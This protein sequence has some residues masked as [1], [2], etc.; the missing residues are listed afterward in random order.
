[1]KTQ[2]LKTLALSLLLATSVAGCSWFGGS[3]K[4]AAPPAPLVDFKASMNPA[5]QWRADV[6]SAG[7][8]MFSP[9]VTAD[10]VYAAGQKGTLARFDLASGKQLWRIDTGS[11]LSAGVGVGDDVVSVVTTTGMVLAY[12]ASGKKMWQAQSPGEVLAAPIVSGGKVIVR[13]DDGRIVAFSSSDGKQDWFY[14]RNNP[15]LTLRSNA[16]AVVAQ[17]AVFAGFPGGKLVGINLGNGAVGW[18]ATVST[19]RGATELERVTDVTSNPVLIGAMICA[20]SYQGRVACFDA[21]NGTPV[22]AKDI[23]STA[24]L[25]LDSRQ[26]YVSDDKGDV[27]AF[28]R[29]SGAGMWKQDKLVRRNLSTPAVVANWVAVG[30]YQG[31]VHFLSQTDG[32]F[33]GRIATDGSAIGNAAM[34]SLAHGLIVQTHSG[35]VFAIKAE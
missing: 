10:S 13:T 16:G 5:V 7:D 12:D 18:E 32:A 26:V 20:A 30:D 23:S 15:S 14:Q 1:M 4:P 34:V 8:Y 29:T 21:R 2:S 11:P 31:Y 24:G 6:G 27:V 28:E 9:A 35:G 19:P 3:E 22:W 33:A 25:D 17:G